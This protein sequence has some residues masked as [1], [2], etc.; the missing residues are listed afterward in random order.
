[1]TNLQRQHKTQSMLAH[2]ES[3]FFLSNRSWHSTLDFDENP[4][5]TYLTNGQIS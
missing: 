4:Q 2:H 3:Q 1:M 5:M